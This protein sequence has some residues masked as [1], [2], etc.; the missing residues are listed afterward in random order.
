[1]GQTLTA[2]LAYSVCIIVMLS[3]LNSSLQRLPEALKRVQRTFRK[4][5]AEII[6]SFKCQLSNGPV[7]G[8]N[9]KIK[10][11]KRVAYGYRN[12]DHFRSR[13]PFIL[14]ERIH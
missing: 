2:I 7:E 13:I 8:I 1:M 4:H 12:F 9:N 14:S 6:A 10:V 3:V 11:I 5:A